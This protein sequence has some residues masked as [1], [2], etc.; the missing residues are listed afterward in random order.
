MRYEPRWPQHHAGSH[1]RDVSVIGV[2]AAGANASAAARRGR[3]L[4]CFEGGD[5][6]KWLETLAAR[7]VPTSDSGPAPSDKR[8]DAEAALV[9]ALQHDEV[10]PN[11]WVHPSVRYGAVGLSV[12]SSTGS[13]VSRTTRGSL[14]RWTPWWRTAR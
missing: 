11:V 5:D 6:A 8:R 7:S 2:E 10:A 12:G 3:S 13:A 9:D 1:D 14:Q 4:C